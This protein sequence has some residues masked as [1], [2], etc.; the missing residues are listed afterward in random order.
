MEETPNHKIYTFLAIFSALIFI[1]FLG[2]THLFD[3]DEIN[4]AECSREMIVTGDYL[5]VYIDYEPFWEKPPLFFW[6]QAAAMHIFGVS[7]F[8]AR[9]P[10]AI[11]G[12]IT[13]LLL[14]RIGSEIRDRQFGLF[15]VLTYI[16]SIL[17]HFYFRSGIIDPMFNLFM[18]L[19]IYFLYKQYSKPE[20]P[21]I[22]NILYAGMFVGLAVLVKGPVGFL[23]PSVAF[24]AYWIIKRKT[25]R[26]TFTQIALYGISAAAVSLIWFGIEFIQNGSWFIEEFV[27]YQ[28]R[29]LT[30]GD[31]GHS[32]PF[33]YHW[34]VVLFGCFPATAFIFKSFKK[35]G[36]DKEETKQFKLWMV[37]LM[38][39]VLIIFSL[40][41]TK[42]VHY[43]SL[44]YYPVTFLGAYVMWHLYN[45]NML[46]KVRNTIGTLL[47]GI[48]LSLFFIAIPLIGIFKEDVM[49]HIQDKFARANLEAD[50]HWLGA[51]PVVGI[52]MLVGVIAAVVFFS[53]KN[54]AKGFFTLYG[55]VIVT[56]TLFLPVVVP[57]LEGY[58]QGAPIEFYESMQGKEVYIEPVRFKSYAHLFYSK[59]PP[60]LS[61]SAVGIDYDHWEEWL[62]TGDIDKPAY[63][64]T[65]IHEAHH[66]RDNPKY[67]DLIEVK[68]ENGFVFFRRDPAVISE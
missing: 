49:P 28:I 62:L 10:N 21:G 4:F 47:L 19:A 11:I 3:W 6:T 42:I 57:R 16:G 5:R 26:V 18:F 37:I 60:Q 14:F 51:E 24:A 68:E 12:I 43:S 23:L 66:F 36:S 20:S 40:V 31:A 8:A 25:I 27:R 7:E 61:A 50:V 64:V 41:K 55:S 48:V 30:T 52:I 1:P 44:S 65:K 54:F 13:V 38:L 35:K 56:L 58:I 9:L 67:P 33:Y 22:S 34:V 2:N 53:K 46:W 29:L 15:W 63:F 17:P 59:K 32:Q 45:K 39:V